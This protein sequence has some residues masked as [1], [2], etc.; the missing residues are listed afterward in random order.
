MKPKDK[1]RV[2]FRIHFVASFLL[3]AMCIVLVRAY[4]LQ[5]VKKDRLLAIARNGYMGSIKLLPKRGA[6]CDR[7][8]HELALSVEVDSIYAHPKRIKD[9]IETA[10]NLSRVLNV[11]RERLLALLK[12]ERSFVWLKRRIPPEKAEMA[13]STISIPASIAF[14]YVISMIP[15]V[16]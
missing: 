2:R 16:Q 5:V 13:V 4:Q 3:L 14:M 8:G 12:K 9:K 15:L 11:N 7:Q 6:I 10:K 1:K